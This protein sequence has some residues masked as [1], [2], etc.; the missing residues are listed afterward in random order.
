VAKKNLEKLKNVLKYEGAFAVSELPPE[1]TAAFRSF[2]PCMQKNSAKKAY[3]YSARMSVLWIVKCG[4]F[5]LLCGSGSQ[6]M[7]WRNTD[8]NPDAD[9]DPYVDYDLST[10]SVYRLPQ[11]EFSGYLTFKVFSSS[12][13][14]QL[15]MTPLFI[16]KFLY[17]SV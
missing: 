1:Y 17:I 7:I 15:R 9:L 5:C 4:D 3:L 11:G 12:G 6:I 2:D 8:P 10:L 13:T 16:S 14:Y